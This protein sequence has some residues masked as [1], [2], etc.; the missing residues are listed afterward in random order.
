MGRRG[1]F[2]AFRQRKVMACDGLLS[3]EQSKQ[4]DI[5]TA[6]LTFPLMTDAPGH[7][8]I[9]YGQCKTDQ[10]MRAVMLAQRHLILA[11]RI[12]I[13]LRANIV[14]ATEMLVPGL[15]DGMQ[16]GFDMKGEDRKSVV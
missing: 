15:C 12:R 9:R 3:C 11:I 2:C 8:T 10:F 4:S 1:F 7:L 16:V 5:C 13:Q 6:G 14:F